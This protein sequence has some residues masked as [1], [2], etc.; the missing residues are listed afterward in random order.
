MSCTVSRPVILFMGLEV[1]KKFSSFALIV[2]ATV[3]LQNGLRFFETSFGSMPS[4]GYVLS[5]GFG[6]VNSKSISDFIHA[7]VS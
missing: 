4:M 7:G 5:M 3:E 1:L 2:A 6:A